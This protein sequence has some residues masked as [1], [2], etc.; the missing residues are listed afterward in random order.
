MS[1][2]KKPRITS[3]KEI[4]TVHSIQLRES[5]YREFMETTRGSIQK[6]KKSV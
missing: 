5:K 4:P 6:T 3:L 2:N 1:K